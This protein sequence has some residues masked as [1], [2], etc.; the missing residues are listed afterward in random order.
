MPK[1]VGSKCESDHSLPPQSRISRREFL[2]GAAGLAALL[3]LPS[4][5]SLVAGCGRRVGSGSGI[6]IGLDRPITTL[7]PAMHRSRT[8]QAVVRNIFDGLVART[9]DMKVVPELAESWEVVDDNTWRFIIRSRVKFHDGSSLSAEDVKFSLDRIITPAAVGGQSS[10]RKGLL[11]PVSEVEATGE[12]EVVIRTSEPFPILPDMLTFQEIVPA[13]YVREIGDQEFARSPVGSG[14]FR[15]VEWRQGERIV[16]E[17]FPDY[18]GGCP[19]IP[20]VGPAHLARVTFKPIPEVAT[21]IASLLSGEADIIQEVPS[22]SVRSIEKQARM[23]V[24][25]CP[26]TRTHYIGLN[27]TIP[28]FNDIRVRLA[29]NHA[30]DLRPICDRVLGGYAKVI[31]GP[32]VPEAFSYHEGLANY[33]FDRSKAKSLLRRAGQLNVRVELDTESS[34]KELAEALAAQLSKAG[35][36]VRVR[37]W[38]WD[39]LQ[40]LL[41]G[42]KRRMF[43]T[44]W[45]NASLD[46]TDILVPLFSTGERGNFTGYSSKK[47]DAL[48]ISANTTFDP[49]ARR[50]RFREV[51]EILHAE[52][53]AIFGIAKQEIYGVNSRVR[54]WSPRPDG[55]LPMHD[56]SVS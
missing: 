3:T 5:A 48:L 11:G 52:V 23:D 20:P 55:M 45:G 49:N 43:L 6:T 10:P 32:L 19:G 38:K 47:V 12:H 14:P 2:S 24:A 9:N 31:P 22:H 8:V 56:V 1:R 44:H 16:L 25:A 18:F 21:R 27:C 53:P 30:V 17:Q 13:A 34:D 35:F 39:L 54:N 41:A 37:V 46:P 51:Q 15:F 29:A 7:D 4:A 28:P 42:L 36:S 50:D 26:G 40:P 33:E